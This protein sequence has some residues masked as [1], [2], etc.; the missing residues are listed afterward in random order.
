[1]EMG[2]TT[3]GEGTRER[4]RGTGE[5]ERKRERIRVVRGGNESR[6]LT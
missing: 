2:D 6:F 3:R 5:G 4:K 1:M